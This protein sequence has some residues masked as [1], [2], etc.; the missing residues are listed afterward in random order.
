ML[1]VQEPKEFTRRF[2][3]GPR[4]GPD[5]IGTL[6]ITIVITIIMMIHITHIIIVSA[7]LAHT[8]PSQSHHAHHYNGKSS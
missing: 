7:T 6:K 5:L 2:P 4:F 1:S 3:S 8:Q